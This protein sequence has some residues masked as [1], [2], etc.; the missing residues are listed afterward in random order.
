MYKDIV[1][2][3]E[4]SINSTEEM[5]YKEYV[6]EDGK[7][8]RIYLFPHGDRILNGYMKKEHS[9]ATD[10]LVLIG[11][12]AKKAGTRL[13]PLMSIT[14]LECRHQEASMYTAWVLHF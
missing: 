5:Y 8:G 6:F 4:E 10:G 9:Y 1:E 3:M 13:L 14:M 2:D 7:G 12:I 11:E